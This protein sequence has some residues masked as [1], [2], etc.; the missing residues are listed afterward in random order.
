MVNNY[1]NINKTIFQLKQ[2]NTNKTTFDIFKLFL[3]LYRWNVC[4]NEC[5]FSLRPVDP[6]YLFWRYI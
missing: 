3:I 5:Y 2:L 4:I 6:L 1:T